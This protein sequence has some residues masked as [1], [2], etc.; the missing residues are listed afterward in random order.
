VTF[1]ESPMRIRATL[2][3]AAVILVD[4]Q[5]S[6]A[7]ELSKVHQEFIRGTANTILG[8]LETLK[9]EF[10]VVVGPTIG[11]MTDSEPATDADVIRAFQ[12]YGRSAGMSRREIVVA[13]A[14]ELGVP[15]KQVY[16]AV[17]R[18]KNV[19]ETAVSSRLLREPR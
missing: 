8:S 10:T 15:P 19:E 17:E 16:A 1:F 18:S 9:G 6:V 2:Q 3:E 13:V 4:R 14:R 12:R 5:I 11:R 7:R